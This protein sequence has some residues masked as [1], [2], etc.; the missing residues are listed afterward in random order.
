MNASGMKKKDQDFFASGVK[1]LQ[2]K[3]VSWLVSVNKGNFG[4]IWL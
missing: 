2:E 4:T 1:E 3:S